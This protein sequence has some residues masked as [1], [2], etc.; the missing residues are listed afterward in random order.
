M[1]EDSVD[2]VP[3]FYEE[4]SSIVNSFTCDLDT[5]DDH[6]DAV[7]H[8]HVDP[9]YIP[10]NVDRREERKE[11]RIR[12][13]K[14][15]V[16]MKNT[17]I[18]SLN[19]RIKAQDHAIAKLQAQ[20]D[21]MKEELVLTKDMLHKTNESTTQAERQRDIFRNHLQKTSA[22][23]E[24]IKADF[25]ALEDK[26]ESVNE[27]NE[28]LLKNS[29]SECAETA[30]KADDQLSTKEGRHYSPAIKLENFIIYFSQNK[31]LLKMQLIL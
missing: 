31:Y 24:A 18:R 29:D 16:K 21:K 27:E 1:D 17:E 20:L 2:L 7:P 14:A 4:Y 19:K 26:L 3:S 25:D 6:D 11:E 12:A 8:L 15:T 22:S 10:R 9:K 13:L 28:K 5:D 23:Y 30:I